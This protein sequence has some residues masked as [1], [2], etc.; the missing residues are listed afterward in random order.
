MRIALMV[1]ANLLL[2]PYLFIRLWLT[3]KRYR[4]DYNPGFRIA[5]VIAKR[6]IWGGNIKLEVYGE[7]NIPKEDGF[8]FYPNHQGLFDSL[9]FFASSPKPFAAVIKKEAKDIILQHENVLHKC[10]ELLLEKERISREELEALFE[11]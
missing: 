10:A 2:V 11:L 1:L 9:T 3:A 4:G 7:E 8:I 6:A 5:K